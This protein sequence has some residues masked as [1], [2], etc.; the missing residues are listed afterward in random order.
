MKVNLNIAG[1][2][3]EIACQKA[4]DYLKTLPDNSIQSCITSPPYYKQRDYGHTEQIGLED[5]LE[6][7]LAKLLLVFNEVRRVLKP[8]GTLWVN[9]ADTYVGGNR[10]KG[11]KKQSNKQTIKNQG[12]SVGKIK[13]SEKIKRKDL[14]LVP[15]ELAKLLRNSGWFL[16]QDIIWQKPNAMPESVKD[17]CTKAHE[18]IFLFSKSAAYY[19][20]QI[21]EP[22]KYADVV[23]GSKGV[24]GPLNKGLRVK[25]AKKTNKQ[26]TK[27]KR[28]VWS[29]STIRSKYKHYA[30]FPPKLVE[31]MIIA[32]TKKDDI[33]L[34][35]F[36][37]TATT[38]AEALKL[39]R[40]F[41]GCDISKKSFDFAFDN[42]STTLF[43]TKQEASGCV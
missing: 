22:A 29:V 21:L 40:N 11:N 42:L 17:R 19:F 37:G 33:V 6:E 15:F 38:G 14:M 32:G 31:I 16:R 4:I 13:P 12:E 3:F 25:Q 10:N 8:D 9:I 5:T 26:L 41:K 24:F 18:Y 39:G 43:K 2:G 30:T 20:N 36:M 1:K 27:N 34:D 35:P 23:R 28:S 7:Y